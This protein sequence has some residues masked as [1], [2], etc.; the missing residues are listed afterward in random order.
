MRAFKAL[1]ERFLYQFFWVF[2][3]DLFGFRI[4]TFTSDFS[5]VEWFLRSYGL[6]VIC[7]ILCFLWPVQGF[8]LA[9]ADQDYI[10][11]V[12]SGYPFLFLVLLP[13]CFEKE[14]IDIWLWASC[15]RTGR[16]T[17]NSE[18]KRGPRIPKISTARRGP[19]PFVELPQ[20]VLS[21][22][23]ATRQ[24][25]WNHAVTPRTNWSCC[26]CICVRQDEPTGAHSPGEDRKPLH[27]LSNIWS[28]RRLM[29]VLGMKPCYYA[30]AAEILSVRQ[31][32]WACDDWCECTT[33]TS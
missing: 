27:N 15:P 13:L 20:L 25:A 29:W 21:S 33:I 5:R 8:P 2:C 1:L 32:S 11:G 6:T 18:L 7:K 30:G 3:K 17:R 19:H 22:T 24:A 9:I 4:W 26:C 23:E 31:G 14:A 28:W 12:W 10:S 16:N